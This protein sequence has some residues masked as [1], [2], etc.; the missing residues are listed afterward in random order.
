[1]A[2]LTYPLIHR[3]P[4]NVTGNERK[5]LYG[6][7]KVLGYLLK[8]VSEN[9]VADY[10]KEVEEL[11]NKYATTPAIKAVLHQSSGFPI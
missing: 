1:M 10:E 6:A 3:D 7:L 4:A 11:I 2:K 8:Q 5:R 9:R